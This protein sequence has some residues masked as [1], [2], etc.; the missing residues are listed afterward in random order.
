MQPRPAA[1]GQWLARLLLLLFALASS[2]AMAQADPPT[3]VGSLSQIEGSVV[4][5]PAGHTEWQRA[6][7]NRPV[8][9]GDRVWTD[10][11]G[12]A[13]LHLG[14][15]VLHLDDESFVEVSALDHDVLQAR[16]HEGTVN[17]RLR[18]LAGDGR[19]EIGTPQLTVRPAQPGDYRIEVDPGGGATRVTVRSGMAIVRGADGA[20]LQLPAGQRVTYPGRVL[21][22]V[23][24]DTRPRHDFDRW[25]AERHRREDQSVAARFLP[26]EVVGYHQLD[27][28]GTWA[29]HPG[30]GVVWYPDVAP[31]PDWAPYRHGRWDWIAPWG[32]TWIDDARWGFAP[33]HYGRWDL[34]G[35]RWAWVPGRIGP[36]PVYAPA[37]VRFTGAPAGSV[38]QARPGPEV[39]WY[40]LAPGEAW[41]PAFRASAAYLREANQAVGGSYADRRVLQ[42]R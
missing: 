7:L 34:I 39:A 12:R 20:A 24:D 29:Q 28:A 32:W 2:G 6:P 1:P 11:G 18:E 16:L 41:R 9:T 21:D 40:P 26:R 5:A 17:T 38:R 42:Q 14:T 15:A 8:T 37:L 19:F 30:H 3:H 10:R 31:A 13:E 35:S 36:R 4:V 33:F 25:V 22:R 23:A 27:T